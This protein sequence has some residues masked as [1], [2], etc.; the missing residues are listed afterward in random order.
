MSELYFSYEFSLFKNIFCS[1]FTL[2]TWNQFLMSYDLLKEIWIFISN[3]IFKIL[4]YKFISS[5][6]LKEWKKTKFKIIL[7]KNECIDTKINTS[8]PSL[9]FGLIAI[10]QNSLDICT[11]ML[12]YTKIRK[13]VKKK[14]YFSFISLHNKSYG[15]RHF[16]DYNLYLKKTNSF[17]QT[18]SYTSFR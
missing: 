4:I 9:L 1:P 16:L 6:K 15:I 3:F 14:I 2:K 12:F 18:P 17:L 11:I 10:F 7:F 13:E 8:I 5:K